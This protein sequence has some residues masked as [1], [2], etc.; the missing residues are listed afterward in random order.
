MTALLE[1]RGVTKRYGALV[2]VAG[3]SFEVAEGTIVALIGPNGAGKT[4]TLNLIAGSSDDWTGE[5]HFRGRALRGRRPYAIARLG[6][7]RTFQVAQPFTEMTLIENVMVGALFGRA[8]RL[9]IPGAR[10]KAIDLLETLDLAEQ[11]YQPAES[12]NPAQRKR[13]E[14][15]RALSTEPRLILIDELMA[16]LNAAEVDVMI[17]LLGRIRDSGISILMVEH[18]MRAVTSLSDRVVVLD[19]GRKVTEGPAAKVL[20]NERVIGAY[21]GRRGMFGTPA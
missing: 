6:I 9:G 15:A 4:T 14:L 1:V 11:A 3:V 16:G 17:E 19:L 21:L 10:G 2:V 20:A 13:L 8:D 12:L 7:A 5:I 18:V